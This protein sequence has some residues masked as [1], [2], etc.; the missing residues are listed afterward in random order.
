MASLDSFKCRKKLTV[1]A[2]TYEYFSLKAAEKNGLDGVSQLPFS[3]KVVL[4]NLLRNE[5]GRTVKKED[6]EAVAAWL[7]TA[8]RREHEIAFRP[9]RVLM[10]DFTGVPAVVDL[11]AMRDAMTKLGGDPDKINPLVPVDLVIDHSV[12]VDHFGTAKSLRRTSS[13]NTSRTRSATAS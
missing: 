12:V 7:E 5:D 8:A 3:M 1:G 4:E 10:Q 2:K 11:A 6:I 13:A 9:A